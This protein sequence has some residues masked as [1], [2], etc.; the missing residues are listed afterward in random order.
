MTRWLALALILVAG[1][2][3]HRTDFGPRFFAHPGDRVLCAKGVDRDH[4][5]KLPRLM[6][7]LE[8]ARADGDVLVTFGHAKGPVNSG[9]DLD[10]LAPA[11]DWAAANGVPSVTMAQL[12]AGHTGAGW[13][14][15]VDDNEVDTWYGWRDALAKHHVKATFFVTRFAE[16][17]PD[18]RAH[19]AALAA[20]GH[21]IESHGKAHLD[22]VKTVTATGLDAYYR[23][24]VAPGVA[25]LAAA[26]FAPVAFSYPYG[27]H[28]AAIDAALL[29]HF[30]IVR[31]TGGPNCL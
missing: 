23:D 21:D 26:G 25:E 18:Q 2:K 19:L 16:L 11:F 28:T 1:C 22:A 7:S 3:Q 5:W 8:S 13:A 12:A 10:E 15:T 9:I 20:D 6:E 31:T 24:E 27:S 4:E 30:K 29:P 17:T 14:F